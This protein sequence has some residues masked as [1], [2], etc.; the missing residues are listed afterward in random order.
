MGTLDAKRSVKLV[1]KDRIPVLPQRLVNPVLSLAEDTA[2]NRRAVAMVEI[3]DYAGEPVIGATVLGHFRGVESHDV[4]AVSDN[5]GRALLVSRAAPSATALFE[6]GVD[7]IIETVAKPNGNGSKQVVSVPKG[8]ARFE[9]ESFRLLASFR[10]I[11]SGVEPSPFNGA[12]DYD[13]FRAWVLNTFYTQGAGVEPSPFLP[14]FDENNFRAWFNFVYFAQG[15]GVEPSPFLPGFDPSILRF[16]LLSS[17]YAEASGVE[18]SPFAI[19]I[20]P[21]ILQSLLAGWTPPA[22]SSPAPVAAGLDELLVAAPSDLANWTIIDGLYLRSFG[23]DVVGPAPTV[24]VVERAAWQANCEMTRS[25][26][27]MVSD[28]AGVEPSPFRIDPRLLRQP[29][30]T[31]QVIVRGIGADGLLLN[32]Q[33]VTEQQLGLQFGS[34]AR[35]VVAIAESNCAPG[36]VWVSDRQRLSDE[37]LAGEVKVKGIELSVDEL[38]E[39]PPSPASFYLRDTVLGA[40]YGQ[41]PLCTG[42]AAWAAAAVGDDQGGGIGSVMP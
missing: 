12:P 29:L 33:P 1:V 8:F 11:A 37:V 6:F 38:S 41:T 30:T 22:K 9:A 19:A 35:L 34:Q 31:D 16:W 32:E 20:D 5:Q 39:P 27:P 28:G 24:M 26:L 3:A 42:A 10:A 36:Q 7:K 18:P 15:T 17:F 4:A 21:A 14:V 40:A 2:G 25:L 13:S 23:S